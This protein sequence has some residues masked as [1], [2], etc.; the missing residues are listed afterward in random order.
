M[1]FQ[2][3]ED[4]LGEALPADAPTDRDAAETIPRNYPP[5]PADQP[6]LVPQA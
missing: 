5:A 3:F 2:S 4:A 1:L 6:A